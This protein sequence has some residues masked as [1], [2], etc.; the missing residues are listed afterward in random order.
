MAKAINWPLQF[1]EE[2][3]AEDCESEYCAFR[4]GD[5][6]YENRY[7]V[8]D[9]VVDIR[10]NHKKIRKGV[11]VGDLRRCA[12]RELSP[13]DLRRQKRALQTREAVIRFLAETYN[14]PVDE[15]TPVTIV[16]YKNQPVIPEEVEAQDDPHM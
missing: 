10:V 12:I 16:C 15:N 8:P 6:Y 5:L 2:V 1:R 7:W 11:V 14:Q 4:L 13:E 9:E 3:I